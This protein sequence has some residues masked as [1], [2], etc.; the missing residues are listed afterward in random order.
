ML[1][2]VTLSIFLITTLMASELKMTRA[3]ENLSSLRQ[4][5]SLRDDAEWFSHISRRGNG[6]TA[7][8]SSAQQIVDLDLLLLN[9]LF[10]GKWTRRSSFVFKDEH[11]DSLIT[12]L[13]VQGLTVTAA[14]IAD[15]PDITLVRLQLKQPADDERALSFVRQ[16]FNSSYDRSPRSLRVVMN[17]TSDPDRFVAE[18]EGMLMPA[19]L[20][21]AE[22]AYTTRVLGIRSND[23]FAVIVRIGKEVPPAPFQPWMKFVKERTPSLPVRLKY[24]SD[25]SLANLVLRKSSEDEDTIR[26][27]YAVQELLSRNKSADELT[28]VLNLLPL[29]PKEDRGQTS[30]STTVLYQIYKREQTGPSAQVFE[31]LM[32]AW[33]KEPTKYKRAIEYALRIAPSV[34]DTNI[35]SQALDLVRQGELIG[36]SLSYLSARLDDASELQELEGLNVPEKYKE[37]KKTALSQARMHL[38]QK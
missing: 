19:S 32:S 35:S 22:R 2:N 10:M 34:R 30:R 20:P 36:E 23:S 4:Y 38:K 13:D 37:R 28:K 8:D 17:A 12:D 9:K 14:T 7:V 11:G 29:N 27:S 21:L 33:V 3:S 15:R 16:M 5:K 24:E 6:E 31:R 26:A 1:K 25:S 18:A